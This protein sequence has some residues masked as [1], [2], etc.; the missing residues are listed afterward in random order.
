M[1]LS[2]VEAISVLER[3]WRGLD[4][5]TSAPAQHPRP[6]VLDDDVVEQAA[7]ALFNFVFSSCGRLDGKH[8]WAT[9][10]ES[11]QEGFRREA[12]TVILAAWPLLFR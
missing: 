5:E 8:Q 6:I 7:E 3:Y 9:C 4:E 11:T 2:Q 12:T 1:Q 10:D